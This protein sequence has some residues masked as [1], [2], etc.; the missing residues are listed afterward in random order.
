M[1]LNLGCGGDVKRGYINIDLYADVPGVFRLD[2][3]SL[4]YV[5]NSIAEIFVQDVI[6]HISHRKTLQVLRHWCSLLMPSGVLEIRC[7]DARKQAELFLSGFWDVE[8]YALMVYG[9]QDFEG[10]QHKT[11][12]TRESLEATLRRLGMK[13]TEFEFKHDGLTRDSRSSSNPNLRVVARKL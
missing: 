5:T 6:E 2:I 13:V 4:P 9:G 3:E 8:T 12:F 11:C 7:P 10:N 1:K